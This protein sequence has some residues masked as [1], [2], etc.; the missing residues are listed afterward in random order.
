MKS[1][2]QRLAERYQLRQEIGTGGFAS[3]FLGYDERLERDVAIKFIL[4]EHLKN[5]QNLTRFLREAQTIARL[6]HSN[7]VQVYDIGEEENWHYLIMELIDG[8]SLREFMDNN[9]LP[10]SIE[11][12][13]SLIIPILEALAYAHEKGV[14]HRD[15]KPENVLLTTDGQPKIVD[16]GLALRDTDVR[17]TASDTFVGTILYLAPEAIRG[18]SIDA[19]ADLYSIGALLYECV[20][21]RPPFSGTTNMSVISEILTKPVTR[22]NELR[23]D[24]SEPLESLILRLLAKTAS[25][26]L[27]TAQAVLDALPSVESLRDSSHDMLRQSAEHKLSQSRLERLVQSDTHKREREA[28]QATNAADSL[29]VFAAQEETSEAIEIERRRIANR[30][31]E[32]LISQINLILSQVS[33]YEQT[34]ADSPQTRMAFSVLSTL[35]RQLLQE[36][37]DLEANLHP[38]VLETLGLEPALESYTNQQ[39]RIS[40][41][42]ITLSLQR[43]RERLPTQIE[44]TIFRVTQDAIERAVRQANA[45]Q[46]IL[47]LERSETQIQFVVEDNGIQQDGKGILRSAR[48]R[49]HA[50]GGILAIN[51]SQYGGLSITVTF[52]ITE[53]VELTERE[54]DVIQLLAEGLTNKE[55]GALLHITARTVKFHLDNIYSKLGVNTR[56]EAAI[57]ALRQGWVRRN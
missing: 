45:T 43:M 29:L 37:H 6:S 33:S 27:P 3:V 53:P 13:V 39:R 48:Q 25:E 5:H 14:I 9:D 17:L 12:V 42:H 36:A 20:T 35:I 19:R 10:L 44:L 18:E 38:T 16:F 8:Q 15:I 28:K 22:P 54:M 26:R 24:I 21:G 51:T 40:G 52:P 46:I 34:M 1:P 41:V 31:Q 11:D 4:P 55:I 23:D 50:L 57:Y 32:T 30:L 56:T 49:I 2:P 7:I 47:L